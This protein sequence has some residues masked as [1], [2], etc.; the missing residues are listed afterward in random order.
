[1]TT[2][3]LP[4]Q[5]NNLIAQV[6]APQTTAIN[7]LNTDITTASSNA[8]YYPTFVPATSGFQP[9]KV[10]TDL[11]YNPSTSE[12]AVR[13]RLKIKNLVDGE[14]VAL[15]FVAG[16]TNQGTQ[17]VALGGEAGSSGQGSGAVA[18]GYQAGVLDQGS[19]A[20]AIG[21]QAGYQVTGANA[22]AVGNL[23][24]HYLQNANAVAIGSQAGETAQHANS[25]VL[26]AT[27]SA[28]NTN[29]A[30]RF[31]V[32]PVRTDGTKQEQ[33]QYNTATNEITHTAQ[34]ISPITTSGLD[35][36]GDPA[37]LSGTSG[38]NSGQHL[39]VVINGVSYKIA[40]QNP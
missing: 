36:T 6:E 17:A 23:A 27:G 9:Q 20:V 30:S 14:Q 28:L 37:L 40:L 21:Y 34:V 26:N 35:I 31:F 32:A 10:N 2:W 29:G 39:V 15:G 11:T 24:G 7:A 1:M 4:L 19:K 38:G 13:N 3:N 33:V 25:I 8:L 5:I 22:V 12:L 18:V 16:Q